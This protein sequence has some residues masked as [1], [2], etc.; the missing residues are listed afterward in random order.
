MTRRFLIGIDSLTADQEVEFHRFLSKNGT[1]WH[2]IS[3]M[4][5]FVPD[6]GATIDVD[7]IRDEVKR[8]SGNARLIAMELAEDIDWAVR[9]QPNAQGGRMGDWLRKQWIGKD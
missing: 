9:A 5:L 3:N 4:W 8:V 6:E 7:A 1:W 2:W